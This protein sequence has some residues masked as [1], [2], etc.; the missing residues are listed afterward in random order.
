MINL[1]TSYFTDTNPTRQ[2]ELNTCYVNNQL[3]EMFDSHII[4]T[5][6]YTNDIKLNDKTVLI[7]IHERPTFDLFFH[8][9]KK[10]CWNVICNSDIYFDETI[11][12]IENRNKNEFIAL[13]RWDVNKDGVPTL[14]NRND[15]QDAWMFYGKPKE[16]LK[17]SFYFGIPGCDNVLLYNAKK[18][19]YAISNP[20]LT[21]KAYHL[22]NSNVRNYSTAA[23]DRLQPPYEL[24]A[25]HQ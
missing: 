1:I 9:A 23:N 8:H 21:I 20:S 12:L 17:A 3:N 7:N 25:P 18:S 10:D 6:V 19:G 11:K 2:Q 14:L 5:D 24:L 13:A 4:L 22:H 16:S 15:A